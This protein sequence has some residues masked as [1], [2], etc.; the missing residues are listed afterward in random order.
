M[1]CVPLATP[2]RGAAQTSPSGSTAAPVAAV[3]AATAA[4]APASTAAPA[5]VTT[6]MP[7]AG[8]PG[9]AWTTRTVTL[10]TED[11]ALPAVLKILAEKGD[12]NIIT[13]PGVASGRNSIHMKDVPI[14][15]AVNLVVRAA[16]LSY[17]RIGNSILV[18]DSK[19]LA[20]ETGLS[21]YVVTLKYADAEDVKAAL[22]DLSAEIQVDKSG[23]RLIIVTSPRVIS[24]IQTT[25]SQLDQ[26]ARQVLLETRIVEVS[27]DDMKKLGVDWE[28]LASQGFLFVEGNYDS[29][30]GSGNGLSGLKVS[31]HAWHARHL[32]AEQLQPPRQVVQRDDRPA[33][34]G[35]QCADSRESEA[36]HAER[37]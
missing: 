23:N 13:G 37:P 15:Q 5:P 19:A 24:E 9:S 17:E 22:K 32:Q 18:A 11:A 3:L 35:G 20:E 12:F 2:D 34:S 36:G 1:L 25:V 27:T 7:P 14:E 30:S 6:P 21:S 26:P 28:K 16:G 29:L 10:D 33:H 4:P 8:S 31:E